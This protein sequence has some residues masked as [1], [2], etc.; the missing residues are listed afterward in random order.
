MRKFC[1]VQNPSSLL[2]SFLSLSGAL[3]ASACLKQLNIGLN[4]LRYIADWTNSSLNIRSPCQDMPLWGYFTTPK[5]RIRPIKAHKSSAV[6]F[7]AG[8]F[9]LLL[10]LNA[11]MTSRV[12]LT[13]AVSQNSFKKDSGERSLFFLSPPFSLGPGSLILKL[14]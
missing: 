12:V 6:Q 4:F 2:F 10:F 13:I 5:Q 11:L 1:T 7:S 9:V 3:V 14:G 8:L